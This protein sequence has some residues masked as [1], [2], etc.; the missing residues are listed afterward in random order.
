MNIYI[1]KNNIMD[2]IKIIN[3]NSI[4]KF[5]ELCPPKLCNLSDIYGQILL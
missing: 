1:I 5:N 3:I 4:N 2:L